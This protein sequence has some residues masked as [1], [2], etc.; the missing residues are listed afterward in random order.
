MVALSVSGTRSLR[1]ITTHGFPVTLHAGLDRAGT[2][3]LGWE[4]FTQ[5]DP[6]VS[7]ATLPAGAPTAGATGLTTPSSNQALDDLAVGADGSSLLVPNR[8]RE[9][10]HQSVSVR[11]RASFAAPGGTFGDGLE[12]VSGLRDQVRDGVRDQ[13]AAAVGTGGRTLVAWSAHDGSEAVNN[14]VFLSERDAQPP[15]IGPCRR[16]RRRHTEERPVAFAASATD[17]LSPVAIA[18]D[19]GDGSRGR[20]GLGRAHLRRRRA[21]TPSR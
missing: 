10:P 12:E 17:A 8:R 21:P 14:R 18:W 16:A 13:A 3:V 9:N 2:V 11:V 15:A 6:A 7:G 5:G 4:E 1:T 19:F 20:G